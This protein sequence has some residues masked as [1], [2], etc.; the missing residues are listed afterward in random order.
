VSDKRR[1]AYRKYDDDF[2]YLVELKTKNM[3]DLERLRDMQS[4]DKIAAN[5]RQIS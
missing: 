3:N 2:K 1:L 4:A 5:I